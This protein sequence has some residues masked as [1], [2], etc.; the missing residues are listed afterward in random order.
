VIGKWWGQEKEN[1]E[2]I[3]TQRAQRTQRQENQNIWLE[4]RYWRGS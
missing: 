3:K 1:K 4:K 2:I